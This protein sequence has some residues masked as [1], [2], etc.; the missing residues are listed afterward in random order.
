MNI[1]ISIEVSDESLR[2]LTELSIKSGKPVDQVLESRVSKLVEAAGPDL[3]VPVVAQPE[4]VPV[5]RG[6]AR[7]KRKYTR[8][9][10]S[11]GATVELT[12]ANCDRSFFRNA[13]VHKRLSRTQ[14]NAFH[15]RT[16]ANEFRARVKEKKRA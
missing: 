12:C 10:V 2:K 4:H 11:R 7:K 9:K 6:R 15:N 8:N 5:S 3:E 14:K 1:K 13:A 16:C